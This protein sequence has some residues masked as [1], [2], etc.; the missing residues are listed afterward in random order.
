MRAQGV[1]KR[2]VTNGSNEKIGPSTKL[3]AVRIT[4]T[5]D[6]SQLPRYGSQLRIH[7]S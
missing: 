4:D 5:P 1:K 2:L 7:L 6:G 3:L